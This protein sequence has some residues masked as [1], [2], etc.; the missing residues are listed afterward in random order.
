MRWSTAK[1]L[2]RARLDGLVQMLAQHLRAARRARKRGDRRKVASE[3]EAV[4][5]WARQAHA[6]ALLELAEPHDAHD[7]AGCAL[8]PRPEPQADGD[9]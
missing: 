4:S 2:D 5:R 7:E 8:P 9:A 6:R 3:L 1:P